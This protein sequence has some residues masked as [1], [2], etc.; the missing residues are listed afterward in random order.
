M[1]LL[2]IN[3][4]EIKYNTW[5]FFT[6]ELKGTYTFTVS[7]L[8][9]NGTP[10]TWKFYHNKLNWTD[11]L[12]GTYGNASGNTS[13]PATF[14]VKMERGETIT[15][16]N[17]N[18]T[19]GA[20]VTISWIIPWLK[21]GEIFWLPLSNKEIWENVI[22]NILWVKSQ[23]FYIREISTITTWSR[24]PWNFVGYIQIGK[25]KIPYYL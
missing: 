24:T 4:E 20:Y 12:I 14:T 15:Y 3:I 18:N 17:T 2:E 6:C 9:Y 23:N 1:E 19:N 21:D 8:G 7:K 22:I 11:T 5:A 25:Y 10:Y 16:T 13:L